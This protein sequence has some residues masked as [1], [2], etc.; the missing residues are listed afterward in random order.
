[1]GRPRGDRHERLSLKLPR[2]TKD[3]LR[4]RFKPGELAGFLEDLA[5][6]PPEHVRSILDVQNAQR[7]TT[8][9]PAV[10][11]PS[12]PAATRSTIDDRVST[13][14][15]APSAPMAQRR[16]R[17]VYEIARECGVSNEYAMDAMRS[18]GMRVKPS[19]YM[20]T[21]SESDAARLREALRG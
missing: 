21:L 17:A 19:S 4:Q 8:G 2:G 7:N 18:L 20:A 14:P 10:P 11:A 16:N 13:P 15:T 6:A 9:T 1:M 3:L 5:T 12:P